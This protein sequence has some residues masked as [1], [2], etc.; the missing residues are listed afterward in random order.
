MIFGKWL[1]MSNVQSLIPTGLLKEIAVLLSFIVWLCFPK[2]TMG[3]ALICSDSRVEIQIVNTGIHGE[4]CT[5]AELAVTF[6]SQQGLALNHPVRIEVLE[7]PVLRLGYSAYGSYD[8]RKDL[9]RVMSP[10]A[11][12]SSATAPLIFNQPF[13]RS[14]YLGIIAH[15]VAHALIH[16]N[17]RIAPLPLGVAAQEYLACVTQ[18]AVLPEKQRERMI[19]DAGVGPW[20]AGDII[21]GVYMEIAPDRFAVKSYLHFQQLQSPSSFVQRLLRSRW[22]YVN[23]D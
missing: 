16:Q 21:S 6:L 20:E 5:A 18:L 9:V 1:V 22:H 12:Q 17:S 13:D 15:E 2:V 11:I 14:H 23:V 4:V 19:S 3:E 7:Q 10:E 8:S